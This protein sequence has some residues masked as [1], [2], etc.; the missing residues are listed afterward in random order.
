MRCQSAA[1]SSAEPLTKQSTG[2]Q[3]ACSEYGLLPVGLGAKPNGTTLAPCSDRCVV[4]F[5]TES[6]G[7]ARDAQEFFK[8]D[9]CPI[10]TVMSSAANK[11]SDFAPEERS[12]GARASPGVVSGEFAAST[13]S[14]QGMFIE[15]MA[16]LLDSDS[17][18]SSMDRLVS[19]VKA[20]F[21]CE[22]VAV[23]LARPNGLELRAISQQGVLN[24]SS[25]EAQLIVEAMNEACDHEAAVTWPGG[26]DT[27]LILLAHRSLASRHNGYSYCSVPMFHSRE[28]VGALLL[29]RDNQEEFPTDSIERLANGIAPLL[30]L[31]HQAARS[32]SELIRDGVSARYQRYLGRHPGRRLIASLAALALAL[33]FVIPT[34]REITASAELLSIDRWVISSPLDGFIDDFQVE[35]GDRVSQGQTLI[36]FDPREIE[37]E[38][39]SRDSEI[40]MAE[41]EFRA[42][43]ASQDRQSTGI[44]RARL[45]QARARREG[46]EAR[47]QR[48][49]L[50]APIDGLVISADIE[51]TNGAS[52]ARGDV[53][54][55]IAPDTGYDVHL[56]VDEIDI[57]DVYVGQIGELAL[58]ASPGQRI[59]LKVTSIHPVAEASNGRNQF[60][61]K[62][63]IDDAGSLLR[64]GQSGVARLV[65][66]ETSLFGRMTHR[67][68][69]RL[70]ELWWRWLG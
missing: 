56:L 50:T 51:R 21:G 68:E 10:A 41:A 22:R 26:T 2:P 27:Q 52:V 13:A 34:N 46:V 65:G 45:A 31:H 55:E 11:Q 44:S 8:L 16:E 67:L 9:G 54:L 19:V 17:L 5:G 36:R 23:A 28:L 1:D 37:L 33:A 59:D 64:P 39:A 60:R 29:E 57:Y 48:A 70:S 61:V 18:E 49:E 15:V 40:V 66:S 69:H 42:A 7:G 12:D 20:Q 14:D 62:A 53:L 6:N 24:A 47:L 35:A 32:W 25:A 63:S 38:A 30:S 43:M 4:P 3:N 58:H